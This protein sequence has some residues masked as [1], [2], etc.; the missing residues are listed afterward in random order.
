MY[1]KIAVA[2][3]ARVVQM[4]RSSSSICIEPNNDSIIA[5]SNA[6]AGRPVD[7]SRPASRRAGARRAWRCISLRGPNETPCERV[8]GLFKL[9]R[10]MPGQGVGVSLT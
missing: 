4:R 2:S 1:S 8:Y 6:E 5:L 3:S 9:K 7:P 10:A